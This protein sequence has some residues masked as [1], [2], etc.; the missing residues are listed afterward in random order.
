MASV[1]WRI[2]KLL[3]SHATPFLIR[4]ALYCVQ[5]CRKNAMNEPNWSVLIYVTK[6]QCATRHVTLAILSRDK[7][8]QQN[9]TIKLQV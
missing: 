8:A 7:V 5:L 9:R 1:T 4:A 6:S 3:N 2:A